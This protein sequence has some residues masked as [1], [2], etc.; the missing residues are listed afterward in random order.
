MLV[1]FDLD[2]DAAAVV[3]LLGVD[4]DAAAVVELM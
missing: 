3:E 1:D 4:S 2:S